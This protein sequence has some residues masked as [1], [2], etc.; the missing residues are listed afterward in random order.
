MHV[1]TG[2]KIINE[3]DMTDGFEC[4]APS[5]DIKK[6][7]TKKNWRKCFKTCRIDGKSDSEISSTSFCKFHLSQF[8][9]IVWIKLY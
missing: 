5:N 1:T 2:D 8:E 6:Q 4:F 9:S 7:K 3:T